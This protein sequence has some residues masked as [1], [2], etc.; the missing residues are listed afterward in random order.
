[1]DRGAAASKKLA[2][3]PS[4]L[5]IQR[6]WEG[7]CIPSPMVTVETPAFRAGFQT[8]VSF[9]MKQTIFS[10]LALGREKKLT[11][12]K[13]CLTETGGCSLCRAIGGD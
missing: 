4:G 11:R 9:T 10:S 13:R 3:N 6:H 12:R 8:G 7:V 1:M 5:S 2:F